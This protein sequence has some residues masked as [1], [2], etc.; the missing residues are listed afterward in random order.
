MSMKEGNADP[1][2]TGPTKTAAK[3]TDP[4]EIAPKKDDTLPAGPE[5]SPAKNSK[6][7][8]LTI[9]SPETTFMLIA[10]PGV[11]KY[12]GDP[13][14]PDE[15]SYASVDASVVKSLNWLIKMS[16]GGEKDAVAKLAGVA[17]EISHFLLRLLER[18]PEMI[19]AIAR[20]RSDWPAVISPNPNWPK[21]VEE[22]RKTLEIGA[23]TDIRPDKVLDVNKP[24]LQ[25]E[26]M[27]H[28]MLILQSARYQALRYTEAKSCR[29]SLARL[30]KEVPSLVD[31]SGHH[32][33]RS[34]AEA[35]RGKVKDYYRD[36]PKMSRKRSQSLAKLLELLDIRESR[37]VEAQ[38]LTSA[39]AKK[40]E[41]MP[42]LDSESATAWFNLAYELL[43]AIAGKPIVENQVLRSLGESS[44]EYIMR[45]NL[46]VHGNVAGI[47]EQRLKMRNDPKVINAIRSKVDAKLRAAFHFVKSYKPKTIRDM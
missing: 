18:E 4:K 26:I 21:S 28:L 43:E 46:D 15:P 22:L 39:V 34:L 25:R 9:E 37:L 47:N 44:G 3:E 33:A 29:D 36:V 32:E 10:P 42:E 7:T 27:S 41:S 14:N 2:K 19:K 35:M 12:Y 16:N 38:L 24:L 13:A 11:S 31:K 23:L 1:K 20:K 5:N 17:S 8:S 6:M 45:E 30:I 40:A